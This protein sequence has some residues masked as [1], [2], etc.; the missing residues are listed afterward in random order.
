MLDELMQFVLDEC[1]KCMDESDKR[2]EIQ[3]IMMFSSTVPAVTEGSTVSPSL[4]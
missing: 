3:H 4:L 1:D 2:K